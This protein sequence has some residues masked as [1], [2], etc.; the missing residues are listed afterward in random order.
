EMQ[1]SSIVNI[2]LV[3]LLL[4]AVVSGTGFDL[5]ADEVAATGRRKVYVLPIREDIMPPLV[6]LVRRGVKEA[7]DAKADL[8]VLDMDTNGGRVDVTEDIIEILNK[9]KGQTATYVN[10]KAFSAGAFIAVATQKIFMAPQSVIG[11]AAP[12]MIA[13]GA[14]PQ[15]MP[16]TMEVKMNSAVRALVR[17]AAEKNGH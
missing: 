5:R 2:R 9:F 17:T 6:Y 14:G 10:R 16:G 11:A 3:T 7:M 4:L 12:I 15:D 13:P 8:L 1:Y